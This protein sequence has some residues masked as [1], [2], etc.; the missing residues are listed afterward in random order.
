MANLFGE[1]IELPT[2][3]KPGN[4]VADATRTQALIWNEEVKEYVKCA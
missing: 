1:T 3:D 4:L 2:I